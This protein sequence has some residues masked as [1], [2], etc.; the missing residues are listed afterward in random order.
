M[1]HFILAGLLAAAPVAAFAE[2]RLWQ[3]DLDLVNRD[4][5]FFSGKLLVAF[6]DQTGQG[7][8][9]DPGA[10]D[11]E[12]GFVPATITVKDGAVDMR[13]KVRLKL[14][15]GAGVVRFGYKAGFDASGSRISVEAWMDEGL[16]RNP[17]PDKVSGPC[18]QV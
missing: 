10:N 4:S 16:V 12:K 14:E 15:Q 18:K 8:V 17:G 7:W 11:L 13:W 2:A 5:V 6:D 1:K 3:C 9:S